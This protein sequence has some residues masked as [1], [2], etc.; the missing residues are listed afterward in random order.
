MSTY[1][2][3]FYTGNKELLND[4]LPVKA[5]VLDDNTRAYATVF[6]TEQDGKMIFDY[7]IACENHNQ[8]EHLFD[9]I[10]DKGLSLKQYEKNQ[11]RDERSC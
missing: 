7:V 3:L 8:V 10:K 9:H 5:M 4:D 6:P 11:K 2:V 1:I